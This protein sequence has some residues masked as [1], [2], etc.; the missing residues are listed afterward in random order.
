MYELEELSGKEIAAIVE[1]PIKTLFSRHGPD[2]A[3][4]EKT[5]CIGRW[6][7]RRWHAGDKHHE[8][9][10]ALERS[11]RGSRRGNARLFAEC[12]GRYAVPR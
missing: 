3:K 9:T 11:V 7:P 2:G 6:P 5:R 1:A 10:Q 12:S 4:P 8:R